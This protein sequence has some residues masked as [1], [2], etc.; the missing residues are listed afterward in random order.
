MHIID[1]EIDKLQQQQVVVE[2]SCVDG[3]FLS[4]IVLRKKKNGEYRLILNLK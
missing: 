4:P 2:A 3:Q 1:A